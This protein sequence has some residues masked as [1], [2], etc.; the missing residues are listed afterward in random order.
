MPDLIIR[1]EAGSTNRLILQDQAGNAVLTTA[2]SGA[3][4]A[5]S[6]FPSGAVVQTVH[7]SFDGTTTSDSSSG[8]S[9]DGTH[10]T[11][12]IQITAGNSIKWTFQFGMRVWAGIS[13][14]DYMFVGL[15]VYHKVDGGSYS[16]A[17][18]KYIA[19][20]YRD[21]DGTLDYQYNKDNA[22]Q[23]TGIHTPSSGTHHHYKL[24][25]QFSV[26]GTLTIGVDTNQNQQFVILEEIQA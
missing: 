5:K 11:K 20:W 24:Y 4:L 8:S 18:S 25:Y 14:P 17:Y 23:L 12:D 6:S 26:G 10:L 7:A 2:D 21:G 3:D 19:D 13:A 15:Y 9:Y 22:Y 1:P 16:N